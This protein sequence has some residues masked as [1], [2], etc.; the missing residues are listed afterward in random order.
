MVF[1][2]NPCFGYPPRTQIQFLMQGQILAGGGTSS[3]VTDVFGNG[4]ARDTILTGWATNDPDAAVRW[5]YA[6]FEEMADLVED[7]VCNLA[8]KYCGGLKIE[9]R[10][11]EGNLT[12]TIDLS[13]PWKRA[14]YRDLVAAAAIRG[15]VS[16]AREVFE[17]QQPASV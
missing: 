12:K 6:N 2:P 7:L 11:A 13:R 8:E 14:P 3:P 9:H 17:V 10:D 16:D 4:F 5:A 1:T 15:C